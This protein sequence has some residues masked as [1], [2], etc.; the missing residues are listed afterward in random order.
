[1]YERTYHAKV[2]QKE[3]DAP[4]HKKISWKKILITLSV[5]VVLA[6]F[7]FFIRI[8]QFQ[9]SEV[10][11]D[12][13]NVAD[14]VEVSQFVIAGLEGKY[15]WVLPKTSILLVSPSRIEEKILKQYPRFKNVS[16]KRKSMNKMA[17]SVVEYPGVYLWCHGDEKCSFMDETGVVFAEAPFFSGSAYLKIY[18]GEVSDYPFEPIT[19]EQLHIVKNIFQKLE[20]LEIGVT[21]FRFDDRKIT[22]T[23]IHH[24]REVEIYFSD[25]IDVALETLYIGLRTRP[26]SDLYNNKTQDLEYFDL[27]FSNKLVY[28]FK[29]N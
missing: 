22:T 2:L 10:E 9:V 15:L 3:N 6:L 29:N 17:V 4:K 11:V 26:L 12:G 19:D 28:K 24:G 27:R 20:V 18:G 7:V 14:P 13:V 25:D 1:M 5:L 16:V 8:P 23:F 21:S